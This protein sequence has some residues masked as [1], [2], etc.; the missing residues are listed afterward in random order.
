MQSLTV[1]ITVAT[2]IELQVVLED[3][4]MKFLRYFYLIATAFV[5]SSFALVC[6]ANES[7]A[8]ECAANEFATNEK[9]HP[10]TPEHMPKPAPP[11]TIAGL[12]KAAKAGD[13]ALL[14]GQFVR[15]FEDDIFEFADE[16]KKAIFVT[17]EGVKV[18]S[19]LSFGYEYFLWGQ[20]LE[21]D[22]STV[23]QALF[24]SPKMFTK[25]HNY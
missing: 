1:L 9:G 4:L 2:S 23:L 10:L 13:Y 21:N 24:L 20:V 22:K 14:R 11:N 15:K 12:K 19:D 7:A 6:G 17:F 16:S 3:Y 5:L 18:P 8:N 25:E